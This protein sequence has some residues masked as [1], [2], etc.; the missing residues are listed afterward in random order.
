MKTTR[1]TIDNKDLYRR[2]QGMKERCYNKNK[3]SYLNYG[4]RGIGICNEWLGKNGFYNFLKWSKENGYKKELQIDRIDNNKNY[5]PDNCRWVD[6]KTNINN[7]RNSIKVNGKTLNELANEMNYTYDNLWRRY[8][9]YGDVKIPNKICKECEKE[10]EPYRNNQRFCSKKCYDKYRK[11][12][13][14]FPCLQSIN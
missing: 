11:I 10:F 6:R 5:S 12:N 3:N 7:R 8:Q 1:L 4:K 9:K 2:Y 14:K 13:N